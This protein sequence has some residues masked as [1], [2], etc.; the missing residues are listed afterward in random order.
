MGGWVG[1]W[2][3]E[4]LFS[5]NRATHLELIHP[6]THPPT[7]PPIQCRAYAEA[8]CKQAG[9]V[10]LEAIPMQKEYWVRICRVGGWVG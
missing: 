2:M 7:H 3:D 6:P 9:N 1:G 4:A 5:F 10:P 8:V